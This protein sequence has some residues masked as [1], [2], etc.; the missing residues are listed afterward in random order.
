MESGQVA[1]KGGCMLGG[2]EAE[3]S[4]EGEIW[5]KYFPEIMLFLRQ[6]LPV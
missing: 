6:S 1:W 3:G 5:A 4:K 2:A